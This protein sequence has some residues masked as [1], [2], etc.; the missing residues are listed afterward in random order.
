MK[1]IADKF[2]ILSAIAITGIAVV[3]IST[4]LAVTS[5]ASMQTQGEYFLER[6]SQ[7]LKEVPPT[8]E[9]IVDDVESEIKQLPEVDTPKELREEI[10]E[11]IPETPDVVKQSKGKLLQ[12]VNIPVGTSLPGCEL[13]NEC[14]TPAQINVKQGTEVIW[15][16]E[17]SSMHTVTSGSPKQGP[18]GVFDSGLLDP[19]E[20]YSLEFNIPGTYQYFCLIHP[21]MVGEVTVTK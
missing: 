15:E 14:F 9:N 8:L 2:G 12:I 4:G 3:F 16:N 20:T 19:T 6:T 18:T 13:I 7:E 1:N 21:W 5:E 10:S 17:D 11:L